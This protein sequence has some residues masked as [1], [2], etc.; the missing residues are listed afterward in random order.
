M[1]SEEKKPKVKASG[2]NVSGV[3]ETQV[4][5]SKKVKEEL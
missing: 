5:K 1:N 3:K 2:K 4:K